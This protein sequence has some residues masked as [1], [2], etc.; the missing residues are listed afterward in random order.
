MF[1]NEIFTFSYGKDIRNV[2]VS[3]DKESANTARF[4]GL[5]EP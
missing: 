4:S 3:A 5:P 2:K 1:E